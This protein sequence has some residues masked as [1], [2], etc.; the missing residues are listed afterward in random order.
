MLTTSPHG[1]GDLIEVV[2]MRRDR[3]GH[4]ADG[5]EYSLFTWRDAVE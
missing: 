5:G 2:L 1:E 4:R 3:L